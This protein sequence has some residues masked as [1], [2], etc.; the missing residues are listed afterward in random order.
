[1]EATLAGLGKRVFLM[2]NVHED[3]PVIFHTRWAMSYLRG[4]VT[5]AELPLLPPEY[6]AAAAAA[7]TEGP[8]AT[9]LA[10]RIRDGVAAYEFVGGDDIPPVHKSVS[11]GVATFPQHANN[12]SKLIEA[13]DR[14]MYV[15]KREGKNKVR[16]A[17]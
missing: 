1:M 5:L 16:V 14:A 11:I 4:P 12:P 3:G 6:T 9:A 13:A 15:A 8:G 7:E 2:H 17:E 10:E